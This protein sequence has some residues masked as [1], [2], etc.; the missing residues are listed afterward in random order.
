MSNADQFSGSG[1]SLDAARPELEWS[2][3]KFDQT[4]N[5]KINSVYE[6]P[7]GEGRRWLTSGVVSQIAGGWRVAV[8]QAYSSGFPIGVTSNAPLNIFNG[9]N[10]PNITGADWRAPIAGSSFDPNV[11]KFLSAAA[12][13]QPVGALGNAPRLNA[14]VRR[15][16]NANEN[17]SLARAIK[18]TKSLQ[19]DVRVEAF[20][21]FNRVVFGPPKHELQQQRVRHDQRRGQLAATPADRPEAVLVAPVRT[22]ARAT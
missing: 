7:F 6:L 12:F 8:I 16:W 1:G 11:D 13:V 4:H 14:N 2:I 3:G 21:I 17:V 22:D 9:T 19:L 20:N 18:A 15:F 10:R 5:I